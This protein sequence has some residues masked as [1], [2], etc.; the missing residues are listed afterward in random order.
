[1]VGACC[2]TILGCSAI[3][4][5]MEMLIFDSVS[6]SFR[7]F[8]DLKKPIVEATDLPKFNCPPVDHVLILTHPGVNVVDFQGSNFSPLKK[9][10][11]S[12][13]YRLQVPEVTGEYDADALYYK[14]A[15]SCGHLMLK[16]GEALPKE[17]KTVMDVELNPLGSTSEGEKERKFALAKDGVYFYHSPLQNWMA[18]LTA[19]RHHASEPSPNVRG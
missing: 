6:P 5:Q 9:A 10:L 13:K 18:W 2:T 14:L 11:K 16:D 1:M 19:P 4:V 3:E 17:G 15:K 8:G 12:A 7:A